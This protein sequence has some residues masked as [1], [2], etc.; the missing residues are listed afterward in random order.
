ML[1]C[2]TIYYSKETKRYRPVFRSS[3]LAVTRDIQAVV[4]GTSI[5]CFMSTTVENLIDIIEIYT[6]L[7]E[8][9]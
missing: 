3:T 8:S 9:E 7:L 2:G 4:M 1:N 6:I 5:L